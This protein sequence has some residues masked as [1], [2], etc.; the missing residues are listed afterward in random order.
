M[1][2]YLDISFPHLSETQREAFF[3]VLTTLTTH[4]NALPQGA[5]TSARL[6]NIVMAKTDSELLRWLHAEDSPVI[7]PIY[8]RYI[9]DAAFSFSR[10]A[11]FDQFAQQG[12]VVVNKITALVQNY[13]S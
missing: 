10:F 4:N 5:P 8:T 6:L 11:S 9:D 12:K 13:D 7:N 3:N 1:S 2:K